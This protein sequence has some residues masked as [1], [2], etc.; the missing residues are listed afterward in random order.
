MDKN[1]GKI[2]LISLPN[3]KRPQYRWI[4]RKREDSRY[5]TRV[6]KVGI[7]LKNLKLKRNND[8]GKETLLP[9]GSKPF[10]SA[11]VAKEKKKFKNTKTKSKS[12]TKT[13]TKSKTKII[14]NKKTKTKTKSKGKAKVAKNK[15]SKKLRA[16]F[17]LKDF[18]RFLKS[19]VAKKT[20]SKSK[21]I[22]I[23]KKKTKSKSKK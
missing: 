9:I 1:I 22:I 17:D 5:V 11:K 15:N 12:K 10:T 13:K 4:I 19:K 21:T 7:L 2:V 6:P 18:R 3:N 8:F 14:K 20:K 23:K 16:S